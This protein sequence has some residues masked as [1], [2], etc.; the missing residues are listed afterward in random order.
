MILTMPGA[1]PLARGAD[2]LGL[3]PLTHT[4]TTQTQTHTSAAYLLC[5]SPPPERREP[6]H[7]SLRI[8][9][10]GG[11]KKAAGGGDS[12]FSQE[13]TQVRL[14][15]VTGRSHSDSVFSRC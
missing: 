10:C 3:P 9:S 13:Q 8:N 4:H 12:G 2:A 7:V 15:L 11:G 1:A 6:T 14:N 5:F